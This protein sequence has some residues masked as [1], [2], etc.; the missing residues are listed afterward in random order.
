ML[1]RMLF[2]ISMI[3]VLGSLTGCAEKQNSAIISEQTPEEQQAEMDAYEKELEEQAN[4]PS[5]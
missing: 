2:S 1:F 3:V 5:S 4:N